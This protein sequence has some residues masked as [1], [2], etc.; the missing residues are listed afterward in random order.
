MTTVR[1]EI[2]VHVPVSTAY[3]QWTQFEELPRFMDGIREVRQLDD[4]HL[5]WV[6]HVGSDVHEWDAE[7][8]EQVPDRV[9][10]WRSL[11]GAQHNGTVRF[12]PLS[13]DQT[14]VTVEMEYAP[15]GLRQGVGAAIGL[16][17]RRTK[18]DLERFKDL[19]EGRG[20]E[21]GAWRGEIHEGRVTASPS[22]GA[23]PGTASP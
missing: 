15:E 18:A 7:I 14:R 20:R 22:A 17:D 3:N 23:P 19:I 4:A 11:S 21:T 12:E 10:A 8:V 1:Q 2:D 5:R 13:L 9:I 6:A 16:D